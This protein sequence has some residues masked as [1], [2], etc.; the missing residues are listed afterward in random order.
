MQIYGYPGDRVDFVSKSASAGS[1]LFGDPRS[2]C[3]EFFGAA[4]AVDTSAVGTQELSWFNGSITLVLREDRVVAV[5]IT[6]GASREKIDIFL[7]KDKL[8]PLSEEDAAELIGAQPVEI[9]RDGEGTL[10][11]VTFAG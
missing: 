3:E 2:L 4:H 11:T 8:S 9:T 7:G 1:L 6:P 5:R 10:A